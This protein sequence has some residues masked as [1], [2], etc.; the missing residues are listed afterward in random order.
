M[1]IFRNHSK[2]VVVV[3]LLIGIAFQS[4]ASSNQ[5]MFGQFQSDSSATQQRA[6][7]SSKVELSAWP[8]VLAAAAEAIGIAYAAG[9]VAGRLA[10]A[11]VDYLGEASIIYDHSI[12]KSYQP[13]AFAEFDN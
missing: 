5:A 4:F 6:K 8:A 1:K 3:M 2:F 9:Y 13:L 11:V 12:D 10:R 7:A